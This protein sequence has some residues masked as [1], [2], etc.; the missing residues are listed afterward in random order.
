MER[1]RMN[2]KR[3]VTWS[4]LAGVAACAAMTAMPGC[5]LLVDFDR[6]KIPSGG[7]ASVTDGSEPP[8]PD[9]EPLPD[10]AGDGM[11]MATD[12]GSD[13]T[14]A[15][16]S[17]AS[18]DVVV[19]SGN[20]ADGEAGAPEAGPPDTGVD[21]PSEAAPDADGPDTSIVDSGADGE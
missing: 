11:M 1:I 2:I 9:S 3:S 16:P 4:L 17:D 14:M 21:A 12:T 6:S 20:K 10:S 7:D 8:T 18:P 13:G 15:P 19:D 5:E